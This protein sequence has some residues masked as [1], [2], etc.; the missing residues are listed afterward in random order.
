MIEL[1]LIVALQHPC[2]SNDPAHN[3]EQINGRVSIN[4]Q[5]ETNEELQA[6]LKKLEKKP[7]K[8][9]RARRPRR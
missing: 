9:K 8:V 2:A 4:C 6:R 3:A 7:R 1:L 5:M